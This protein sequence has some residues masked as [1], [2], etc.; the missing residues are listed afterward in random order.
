MHYVKRG[1][2]LVF[3]KPP[4]LDSAFSPR[5]M[6]YFQ[7]GI[8][9]DLPVTLHYRTARGS[10]V[11]QFHY[12]SPEG[13]LYP[14]PEEKPLLL[15]KG[16]GNVAPTYAYLP[17]GVKGARTLA[18]SFD[19]YGLYTGGTAL[20]VPF[21][22][23]FIHL[24]TFNLIPWLAKDPMADYLLVTLVE[25]ALDQAGGLTE[26][27]AEAP[28][29][30]LS[31]AMETN[32]A[33]AMYDLRAYLG[34][35]ERISIQRLDGTRHRYRFYGELFSWNELRMEG[36]DLLLKGK[37]GQALQKIRSIREQ[38]DPRLK[39]WLDMEKNLDERL[40]GIQGKEA[41]DFSI[42][43]AARYYHKALG[44]LWDGK[45]LQFNRALEWLG[46]AATITA[47]KK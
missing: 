7:E 21:G 39:K 25:R 14:C 24:T 28:V 20:S 31:K 16:F 37:F 32:M 5:F 41:H 26:A 40:A 2:I 1:G 33:Y 46:K 44:A 11:G 45:E 8:V 12:I 27:E 23:G 30:T 10:F 3:L 38:V 42:R 13:G 34:L 19:A 18:G 43:L 9:P 29:K 6:N 4:V 36:L 47:E 35:G 22:K 15:S 17:M